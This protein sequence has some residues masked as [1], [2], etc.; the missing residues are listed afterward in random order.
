MRFFIF[1]LL[2]TS[3]TSAYTQEAKNDALI[4]SL[5]SE[6]SKATDDSTLTS[7]HYRLGRRLYTFNPDTF[8]YHAQEMIR[9]AKSSGNDYM[10]AK[11]LQLMGTLNKNKGVFDKALEYQLQ[12]LPL[13]A[14]SSFPGDHASN[15]NAVGVLYKTMG[16]YEKA[17]PYYRQSLEICQRERYA[18][19][20]AMILNNIGTIHDA[21]GNADSAMQY[22]QMGLDT[23]LVH[24][25]TVAKALSYNNIGEVYAKANQYDSA[26]KYFLLTLP[27]DRATGNKFG[28]VNTYMNIGSSYMLMENYRMAHTYLD[29]VEILAQELNAAYLLK[30]H[31]FCEA[32][33]FGRRR[34]L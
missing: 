19:P 22:Y 26:Q 29:T 17:L 18:N 8:A 6:L 31:P 10:L 14:N 30:K 7:I 24:N 28:S 12:A 11:G 27:I 21:L 25:L 3:A 15:L 9:L 23:C 13:M 20:C 32:K 5:Y 1:L 2:L 34:P 33:S 4:D 16:D